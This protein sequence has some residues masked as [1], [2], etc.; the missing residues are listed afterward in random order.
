MR[1][2]RLHIYVV[3]PRLK[4]HEEKTRL[5]FNKSGIS[6]CGVQREETMLD[7]NSREKCVQGKVKALCPW[8]MSKLQKQRVCA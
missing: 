2:T 4:G 5:I 1:K 6:F 8:S 7:G 3:G